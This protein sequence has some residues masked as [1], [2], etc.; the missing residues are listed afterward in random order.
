VLWL[1]AGSTVAALVGAAAAAPVVK[2]VGGTEYAS[3]VAV[4][5]ILL[6]TVIG[7]TFAVVMA[8]QWIGR[9]LFWQA[10]LLTLATGALNVVLNLLVIPRYSMV[11]AAWVSVVTYLF[12]MVFNLVFAIRIDRRLVR[13]LD[14]GAR[15]SPAVGASP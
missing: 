8:P 13:G 3:A 5:Q 4:L 1:T 9:G 12:A 2:L 6:L 15:S 10:S 7:Q 14:L 11:G